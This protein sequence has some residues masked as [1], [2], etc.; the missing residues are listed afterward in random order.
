MVAS[1]SIFDQIARRDHE[2]VVFCNDQ[3][4][5]LRAIIGI[6]STALGPSLGGVRMW[7]YATDDDALRDVLRLSR[8][9]TYKAAVAGLNLGGG[10]SVIIGDPR[11]DKS[12][13]LMRTFGRFV[14][15]LSGRYIA[16]EDMGTSEADMEHIRAETKYV[17]GFSTLRGGSGDPS[18]VTALGVYVGIKACAKHRYGSDALSGKSVVV[19]GAGHVGAYIVRHLRTEGATVYVADIDEAR[20]R[21]LCAETGAI[22]IRTDEVYST[23][24][25]I[26]C[27]AAFGGIVNDETIAK[28][29][30]DIIAGAANNVL[31]E[32]KKHAAMLDQKG[33]LYA[34]DYVI[35]AGGLMSVANELQ[36]APQAHSLKQAETIYDILLRIFAIAGRESVPTVVASNNLAEERIASIRRIKDVYTGSSHFSGLLGERTR[37]R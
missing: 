26:F 11:K 21:S 34:P 23:K 29:Q 13:A 20:V 15:G 36:G 31:G 14:E 33:I 22:A 30:C 6:H 12:E 16:A 28:L 37:N 19:Q 32:E 18:P 7:Q 27:P 4:S 9:M 24:C 5:G 2:Q 8:A 17:T 1:Q 3:H 35:N 25:D 10:K